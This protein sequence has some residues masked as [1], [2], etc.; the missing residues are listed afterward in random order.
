MR[1]VLS[2]NAHAYVGAL[3]TEP[4]KILYFQIC[5]LSVQF[6][7]ITTIYFNACVIY[8]HNLLNIQLPNISRIY[9]LESTKLK[10]IV[11]YW[12]L[13]WY[14]TSRRT[15]FPYNSWFLCFKTQRCRWRWILGLMKLKKK[16]LKKFWCWK[17]MSIT[18]FNKTERD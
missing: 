5:I 8:T 2:A 9:K 12:V 10:I 11:I 7:N 1:L 14:S 18:M 16:I 17:I 13:F 3:Q 4:I 6:K 15:T